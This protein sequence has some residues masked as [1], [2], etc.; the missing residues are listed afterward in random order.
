PL[1]V[2]FSSEGSS[3]APDITG[4]QTIWP[5]TTVPDIVDGG[6]PAAVEL[7]VKF[8]SDVAGFVTAIRFYKGAANTGT[9]IGSLWSSTGTRLASATFTGES[10]SGWQQLDFVPPIAIQADTVYVA[11]YFAPNGH[12]SASLDY[13]A[14]GGFDSP[15]LHA[16]ADGESGGNGVYA[17]GATSVFPS[18]T[19]RAQS[20]SVDVVFGTATNDP[21]SVLW[22]FGDGTPASTDPAPSHTYTVPGLYVATLTVSDA[23]IPPGTATATV[24]ITVGILP[25]VT[26]TQPVDNSLFHGGQTIPLAGSAIDAG[27][28]D[29]PPSALQWEIRFHHDT[30]FH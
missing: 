30:H 10:A 20:Y 29:L 14:I 11:S 8:R 27:G 21:P 2:Q 12:Y 15:P 5:S 24:P 7:G 17:Y 6:D 4:T 13:F 26:I 1:T 23:D 25:A 18:N 22:D 28:H 9:H 16:L 3:T 19:F